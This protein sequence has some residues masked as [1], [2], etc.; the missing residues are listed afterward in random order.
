MVM[1]GKLF[2]LNITLVFV[3]YYLFSFSFLSSITDVDL[4]P[5]LKGAT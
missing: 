5:G 3:E 2:L 1:T 4:S